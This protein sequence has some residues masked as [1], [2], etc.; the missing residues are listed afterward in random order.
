MSADRTVGS[1][2]LGAAGLFVF[3]IVFGPIAI[4]LGLSAAR[5]SAAGSADRRAA[6]LGTALGAAD[7]LVLAILV[8]GK[9]HHG[10]WTWQL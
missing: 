8:A 10:G 5:R 6:L 4:A 7:L 9:A 3:N 2:A 1:L